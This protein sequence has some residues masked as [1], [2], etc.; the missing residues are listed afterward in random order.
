MNWAQVIVA[1]IGVVTLEGVIQFFFIKQIKK[2]K[3]IENTDSQVAV[4][5][6]A[7][8]L[9]S[10]QLDN[11]H[12]TIKRLNGENSELHEENA[13]LKS[14]QSCLFDDMCIHKGCRIRKPHQGQG[15]VWYDNYCKDPSLG[16]DYHSIDTLIKM[17]RANRLKLEKE[18]EKEGN[19]HGKL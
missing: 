16:A 17:D 7:N 8:D 19:N 2:Q 5:Q 9:L 12:E 1:I 18:A 11:C 4:A 3:E 15:Q 6:H 14:A 10:K 13:V